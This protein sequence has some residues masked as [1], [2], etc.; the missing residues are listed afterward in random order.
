MPVITILMHNG[1][2]MTAN[3]PKLTLIVLA[4]VFLQKIALTFVVEMHIWI[5]VITV[6]KAPPAKLHVYK[7]VMVYG[8]VPPQLITVTF[9]WVALQ[10]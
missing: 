1:I 6:L 8:A 4:S 5:I 10:E 3:I 2:T 9:V 7:I